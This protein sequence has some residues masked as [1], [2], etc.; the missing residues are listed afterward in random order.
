M[1]TILTRAGRPSALQQTGELWSSHGQCPLFKSN[2]SV[3]LPGKNWN[4]HSW[5]RSGL[6]N[7]LRRNISIQTQISK[8]CYYLVPRSSFNNVT[9][10]IS[11]LSW[12]SYSR[13]GRR[14]TLIKRKNQMR[15]QIKSMPCCMTWGWNNIK[16]RVYTYNFLFCKGFGSCWRATYHAVFCYMWSVNS[17]LAKFWKGILCWPGTLSQ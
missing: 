9:R 11:I 5:E 17:V 14:K 13:W 2:G 10:V 8:W 12:P 15:P 6:W 7:V 1:A 16:S 4:L 3:L